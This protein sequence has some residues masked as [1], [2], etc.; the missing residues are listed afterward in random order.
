MPRAALANGLGVSVSGS[1][2]YSRFGDMEEVLGGF[3]LPSYLNWNAGATFTWK[4]LS[5]DLRYYDTNLSKEDCYVFTGATDAVAGGT[6]DPLRNPEGLRSRWC[7]ATDGS[8]TGTLLPSSTTRMS[9][10]QVS[11]RSDAKVRSRPDWS[12]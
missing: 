10:G 1:L 8:A 7:G 12:L 5:L 4:T 2:G 9:A 11:L 6:I 3:A